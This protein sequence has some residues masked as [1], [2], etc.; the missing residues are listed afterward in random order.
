MTAGLGRWITSD[1]H[2]VIIWGRPPVGLPAWCAV[3]VLG[4]CYLY[5]Y[6]G[7]EVDERTGPLLVH[8][9]MRTSVPSSWALRASMINRAA[10][11]SLRQRMA[12]RR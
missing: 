4:R 12:A 11:A 3:D 10:T 9:S 7:S 6:N 2:E 1:R 8:L 5:A